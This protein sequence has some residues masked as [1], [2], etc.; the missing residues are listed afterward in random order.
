M[1]SSGMTSAFQGWLKSELTAAVYRTIYFA[2]REAS[3]PKPKTEQDILFILGGGASVDN[4]LP[5]HW[6]LISNQTSIGINFWTTHTFVPDY[7]ALEKSPR[8]MVQ[9]LEALISDPEKAKGARILW[10]G[11]PNQTSRKLLWSFK[12]LGGQ[13]W[14]YSGW[15]FYKDGRWNLRKRFL[16]LFRHFQRVPSLFRPAIDAGHTVSRLITLSAMNG[17]NTVVLLGVDLGGA[18]FRDYEIFCEQ[19]ELKGGRDTYSG[20]G[21]DGTHAVDAAQRGPFRQ[22]RVIPL[23]DAWI[24]EIGKGQLLDGTL[25]ADKPL[26]LGRFH[27]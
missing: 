25:S 24:Q 17:W 26:G 18:Y 6:N 27:W 16:Q 15:P 4:L 5:K 13:V 7:Y 3:F 8:N 22:S 11:G 10:F 19:M 1:K 20:V 21:P 9:E 2:S 12:L 23:L 14:F